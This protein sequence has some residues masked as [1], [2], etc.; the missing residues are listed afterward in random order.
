V[1][2]GEL[3]SA[4]DCLK[5]AQIVAPSRPDLYQLQAQA[6]VR[7]GDLEAAGDAYERALTLD[8]SLVMVWYEMG[9]LEESR[10]AWAVARA[11]YTRALDLLPTFMDAALALA[12]GIRCRESPREAVLYL[13]GILAM[14]PYDFEA[15]V[16]LGRSLFDDGRPD[17][18]GEAYDRVLRFIPNHADALY[19]RGLALERQRRLAEAVESWHQAIQSD[20]AGQYAQ[21]A[22]LRMR[23]ARDLS[24]IFD[25]PSGANGGD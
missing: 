17:R 19:F 1:S 14:E 21:A 10:G 22:R 12:D 23:S 13:V 25:V 6:A 5:E 7:L 16:L 4:L 18:A 24:A 9:R 8:P 11:A 2:A 3:V 15:L 20:P